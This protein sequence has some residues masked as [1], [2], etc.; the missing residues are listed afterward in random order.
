MSEVV[1]NLSQ[2]RYNEIRRGVIIDAI[3]LVLNTIANQVSIDNKDKTFTVKKL[4]NS[5]ELI[6]N[7]IGQ[8]NNEKVPREILESLKPRITNKLNSTFCYKLPSKNETTKARSGKDKDSNTILFS[9]TIQL[10]VEVSY[11]EIKKI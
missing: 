3:D 10:A 9:P 2:K 5:I 6:Y 11:N 8:L 7:L 1:K 4:T